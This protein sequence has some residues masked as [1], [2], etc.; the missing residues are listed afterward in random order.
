MS[1]DSS[2]IDF[3]K[4][5]ANDNINNLKNG[6]AGDVKYAQ[7]GLTQEQM[8]ESLFAF[9]KET[10]AYYDKNYG[11]GDGKISVD[12]YVKATADINIQFNDSANKSALLDPLS[13]EEKANFQRLAERIGK[14]M[15]FNGDGFISV[16]EEAMVNTM[17]DALSTNGEANPGGTTLDGTIDAAAAS[18]MLDS[19]SGYDPENPNNNTAKYVRG[20]TISSD[21]QA[22]LD[23]FTKAVHEGV[24]ADSKKYGVD[25]TKNTINVNLTQDKVIPPVTSDNIAPTK[26]AA[27]QDVKPQASTP[28]TVKVEKFNSKAAKEGKSPNDCLSRIIANN[29][30]GI[31]PY[32]G[33]YHKILNKIVAVNNLKNPNIIRPGSEIILPD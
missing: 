25:L 1:I 5:A 12:E 32:S 4:K 16:E 3:A 33:E 20:E 6:N 31:K 27:M 30:P 22:K 26:E 7:D 24:T 29:Y 10:L 28:R 18:S 9:S 23:A 21:T 17:S 14:N 8:K 2:Y 19:I 13:N 15:D 11:N